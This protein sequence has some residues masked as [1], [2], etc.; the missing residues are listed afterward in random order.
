MYCSPNCEVVLIDR[1]HIVPRYLKQEDNRVVKVSRACHAVWHYCN[2]QLLGNIEDY[3]AYT[4]LSKQAS[5][6]EIIYL[7]SKLAGTKS[8][9]NR[10]G[11][12]GMSPDSKKAAS[13]K[14]GKKASKYMSNSIW[15]NNGII[16]VR[17]N[18]DEIVYGDWKP[19]KLKHSGT[20]ERKNLKI[21][22]KRLKKIQAN[23]EREEIILN[24]D[25]DFSSE[26][27]IA[28]LS[29]LL[30]ISHTHVVRW[31]KEYMPE[32]LGKCHRRK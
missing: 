16:N 9:K 29:K 18:K 21:E 30:E 15:L 24:S 22:E 11:I 7:G 19:G 23:K 6:E 2:Y 1:H 17:V 20:E 12:H 10:T 4:G 3:I 31:M 28:S 27:W 32:F 26:G 8:Y 25:I 5:N 13:S 14:G